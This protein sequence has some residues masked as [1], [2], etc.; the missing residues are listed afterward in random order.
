[1]K[2]SGVVALTAGEF[3]VHLPPGKQDWIVSFS[4]FLAE[5]NTQA[6]SSNNIKRKMMSFLCRITV[7]LKYNGAGAKML[8]Q[9]IEKES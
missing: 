6:P 2:L 9:V 3:C 5:T 7:V 1:M 8:Q 4:A